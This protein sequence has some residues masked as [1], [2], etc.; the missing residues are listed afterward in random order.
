MA[1]PRL[2]FSAI[3]NRIES[4]DLDHGSPAAG[5]HQLADGGQLN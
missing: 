4:T 2:G 3:N 1:R 5:G